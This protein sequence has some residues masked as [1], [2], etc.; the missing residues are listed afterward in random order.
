MGRNGQKVAYAVKKGRQ[1]GVFSSC[2][3]SPPSSPALLSSRPLAVSGRSPQARLGLQR[4]R[5]QGL[6]I[7]WGSTA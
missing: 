3:F 5:P 4:R 1:T 2:E 6:R 7:L